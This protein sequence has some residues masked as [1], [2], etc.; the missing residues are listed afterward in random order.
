[1]RVSTP[2]GP[3]ADVLML[4]RLECTE[5]V[6]DPF[7]LVLHLLSTDASVDPKQLLR[8]PMVVSVDM[9]D[10]SLRYF[11][12]MVRR[13]V[14]LG[15]AASLVSYRAEVVPSLSFL[16]LTTDCRIFQQKTV[17]DII[18]KV[19]DDAGITD[20][21]F[22]L[23]GSY[24]PREYCVQYR[25]SDFDFV[26]RLME[27][28][29]M[30]YFFEHTKEKHTLVIADAKSAIR[31]S[32][33][34]KLT[35]ELSNDPG[36]EHTIY[37]LRIENAVVSG[38][39]TLVDYNERDPG[40]LES[41]S[42]GTTSGG[43]TLRL[44]D[45]PGKFQKR[46]RGD[47]YARLR[48]EEAEALSKVVRAETSSRGVVPG[49]KVDIS[50][51]YRSDVDGAYQI[52]T[53]THVGFDG[54]F[55][56]SDNPGFTFG[57]QFTCIPAAVSYRPPRDTPKAVVRGTQT[58]VVVGPSGEDIYTDKYG[59]VKVKFFWDQLAERNENSSCWVRVSS[60][61]AGKAWG[62]ISIPRIG[63]EVVVDFL[64]GDPDC[65]II[66]GRVYNEDQQVPYTLPDNMTQSGVKSRSSKTGAAANFN[67]FRFEDKKDSEQVFLHAEKN[68]DLEVENDETHWVGHDR[69][70]TIDNDETV[71]VKGSRTET[72]EKDEKITIK[73]MRSEIVT[74][75][76]TIVIEEGD[77]SLTV[78]KGKETIT[79][80]GT[81][82][83]TVEDGD[84]TRQVKK[85]KL[86]T[87]VDQGNVVLAVSMG[88]YDTKVDM[89]NASLKAGMGKIANEA[90]QS[91]EFKVGGSS[92]KIDQAGVTIKGLM[93]KIEGT[94]QTEVKG[95][96]TKVSGDAMLMVKGGITMIN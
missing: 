33:V 2:K 46:A 24:E 94:V 87:K 11:H 28:E 35:V 14:Q 9:G 47:A 88:N 60:T 68:F 20:H 81:R 16:T 3:A 96:I 49:Y 32:L 56:S 74:K 26:S 75:N 31:P 12:G 38:K 73:G 84:E 44:Y 70:K 57:T 59:R 85:G 54:G 91:I 69:K 89:G 90:M 18:K 82:A 76:E 66:V 48:L 6:S 77:R 42:T 65:P 45:Y 4:E 29:G 27:E 92:I 13:F 78:T 34:P 52:L 71:L 43:P 72:V 8:K 5:S 19:L 50:D 58:A 80:K 61:W 93:V 67:E 79:V 37:D 23:T 63:Q 53:A 86:E 15:R 83:I 62:A 55:R 51:H 7:E 1:M 17:Q 40:R 21:R 39:T 95:V 36:K 25:E 41:S 10:G 22:V 64:E 30:F